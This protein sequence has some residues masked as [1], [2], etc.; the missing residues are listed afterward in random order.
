MELVILACGNMAMLTDK[1]NL[2]II[3]EV[4]TMETGQTIRKMVKENISMKK[5][6]ITTDN[7]RMII[8]KGKELKRGKMEVNLKVIFIIPKNMDK[9]NIHGMIKH[10]MT[11]NGKIT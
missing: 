5:V 6:Q 10:T 2:L 4:L 3:M 1:V 8:S 7:G 11:E 9:E